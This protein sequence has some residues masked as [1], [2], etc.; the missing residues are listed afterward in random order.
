MLTG[1]SYPTLAEAAAFFA[2][3]ALTTYVVGMIVVL[4]V[5]LV[6]D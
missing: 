5:R 4:T 1:V 2:L 3:V 6:R